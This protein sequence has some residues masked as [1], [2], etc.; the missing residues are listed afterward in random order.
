MVPFSMVKKL[1]VHLCIHGYTI[2]RYIVEGKRN[3]EFDCE[4]TRE[5]MQIQFTL[6]F[7]IGHIKIDFLLRLLNENVL[8]FSGIKHNVA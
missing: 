6:N 2:K 8:N 5:S 3:R 4:R 7:A 1:H